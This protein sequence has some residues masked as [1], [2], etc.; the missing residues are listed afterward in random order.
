M[1]HA[2]KPDSPFTFLFLCVY[3]GTHRK[4]MTQAISSGFCHYCHH[5]EPLASL[6]ELSATQ[7]SLWQRP[8]LQLLDI[9]LFSSDEGCCN[10]PSRFYLALSD[11]RHCVWGIVPPGS[12]LEASIQA[13]DVECGCLMT[14]VDYVVVA[15]KCGKCVMVILDALHSST[16]FSLMGEPVVN[17]KWM[18]LSN[19]SLVQ[20]RSEAQ[21]AT[22]AAVAG[23][24]SARFPHKT[25]TNRFMREFLPENGVV[26]LDPM[27]RWS[28][29]GR[30]LWKSKLRRMDTNASNYGG[31]QQQHYPFQ[32]HENEHDDDGAFRYVF[33]CVL[34]DGR[35][36]AMKLVFYGCRRHFE[37]VTQGKCVRV[38]DGLVKRGDNHEPICLNF[39]ER[40]IVEP[41]S[42]EDDGRS[43]DGDQQVHGVPP[44]DISNSMPT[45]PTRLIG[46]CAVPFLTV[47]DVVRNRG[48]GDLITVQGQV[49]ATQPCVQIRTVRG[50][51]DKMSI[52]LRECAQRGSQAA[53]S[54]GPLLSIEVTLW[55][56]S[57]RT[58]RA[59]PGELWC[60]RDATVRFFGSVKQ[61]STR[62]SSELFQLPATFLDSWDPATVFAVPGKNDEHKKRTRTIEPV[63]LV[64]E[65]EDGGPRLEGAPFFFDVCHANN[66]E[67][68]FL[69][70]RI[71]HIK[72][73][74]FYVACKSCGGQM[75]GMACLSCSSSTTE[76]RFLLRMDITDGVDQLS[77]VVGFTSVAETL[78]GETTASFLNKIAADPTFG[79]R[80]IA[81]LIGLPVLVKVAKS[82]TG[83]RHILELKHVDLA[84]TAIEVANA[85]AS[86][87]Y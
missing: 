73:P 83:V 22:A 77:G 21:A 50:N 76:L 20:Q 43:I 45:K 60:I 54:S 37:S 61:L 12:A 7:E 16:S 70:C 64:D 48:V 65:E 9:Q 44:D 53:P 68:S 8:V 14:I 1:K 58:C 67:T 82:G 40:S 75:K 17:S 46:A 80:S 32:R 4:R 6:D 74:L 19:K 15:A 39:Q 56:E 66:A 38:C 23:R 33:D 34:V 18:Q 3:V 25:F 41:L 36:D 52:T 62:A 29:S 87:G 10:E 11:S 85:I 47:G 5:T 63:H 81:D 13:S 57:A 27:E 26:M 84:M 28:V 71:Y 42:E 30:V 69:L 86:F 49:V 51:V 72:L 24:A 59:M 2:R 79:Q 78:F 31:Q 55:D 35:G